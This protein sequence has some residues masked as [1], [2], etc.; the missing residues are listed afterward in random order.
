MLPTVVS[1]PGLL[2]NLELSLVTS[3]HPSARKSFEKADQRY[4]LLGSSAGFT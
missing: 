2:G 4:F 1:L 3:Y